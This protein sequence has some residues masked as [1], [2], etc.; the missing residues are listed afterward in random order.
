MIIS[1][2]CDTCLA[3]FNEHPCCI[4]PPWGSNKWCETF[5]S[6]SC[7]FPYH[8]KFTGEDFFTIHTIV[9]HLAILLQLGE[10]YIE[11][12]DLQLAK[13]QERWKVT[14]VTEALEKT[15]FSLPTLYQVYFLFRIWS[16]KP[17][18]SGG[19]FFLSFQKERTKT[20][21]HHITA[22]VSLYF[23]FSWSRLQHKASSL[24]LCCIDTNKTLEL[25]A[26]M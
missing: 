15:R 14:H 12:W 7:F 16:Y 13:Q 9:H 3:K 24:V 19:E 22:P 1:L 20:I 2:K 17:K 25:Y 5:W 26:Y 10:K 6:H 11:L 8:T 18:I 23:Q 4:V 21:V